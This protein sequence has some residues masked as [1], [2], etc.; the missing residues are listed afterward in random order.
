MAIVFVEPRPKIGPRVDH[1]AVENSQDQLLY[2]AP[3]EE[4]AIVWAKQHWHRPFVPRM[5]YLSDKNKPSHWR[6]A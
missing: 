6:E 2:S 5:R 1:F 4:L 3:T